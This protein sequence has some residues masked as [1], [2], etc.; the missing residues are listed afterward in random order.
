MP[1]SI[2]PEYP[3]LLAVHQELGE[4]GSLS[5]P[6][7]RRS[8]RPL[9]VGEHEDVEQFGA[10]SGAERV[11]TLPKPALKLVRPDDRRLRPPVASSSAIDG[12]LGSS[13]ASLPA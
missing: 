10:G 1:I 5:S 4:C 3:V 12:T 6:R 13:H 7:T 2:A 9:E 8:G 11:Q